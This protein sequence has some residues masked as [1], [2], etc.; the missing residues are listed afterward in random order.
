VDAGF[1]QPAKVTLAGGTVEFM[2]SDTGGAIRGP[3]GVVVL[4]AAEALAMRD[5]ASA[6]E[7]DAREAGL[8]G[9]AERDEAPL[10]DTRR[11]LWKAIGEDA[12]AIMLDTTTYYNAMAALGRQSPS[13]RSATPAAF[14][15]LDLAALTVA[16]VCFDV[17]VI[18]PERYHPGD[19]F[20][21]FTYTLP[22]AERDRKAQDDLGREAAATCARRSSRYQSAWAAFLGLDGQLS[23]DFDAALKFFEDGLGDTYGYAAALGFLERSYGELHGESAYL[24]IQTV[25]AVYNDRVAGLLGLPYLPTS[26]RLP[27]AA[28]LSRSRAE[29]LDGIRLL[30][31]SAPGSEPARPQSPTTPPAPLYAPF[32]LGLVL[33]RMNSPDEFEDA[34]GYWRDRFAP[35]RSWLRTHPQRE[36]WQAQPHALRRELA[37]RM[38]DVTGPSNASVSETVAFEVLQGAASLTP[39]GPFAGSALKILRATQPA[40]GLRRLMARLFKPELYLLFS[41]SDEARH[42]ATLDADITR[43]WGRRLTDDSRDAL[44]RIRRLNSDR[45]L[46]PM[47]M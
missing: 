46:S 38:H 35:F 11:A 28:D 31:Q 3:Q 16:G 43:I 23:L 42:V 33:A 15:L 36:L 14:H 1:S 41:I 47:T 26:I 34:V 30:A 2:L 17:V 4:T 45:L 19:A 39:V 27:V 29:L 21:D 7:R 18:Q 44:E 5:A 25:R 13:P 37:A 10:R 32:L 9:A 8:A 40:S 6:V 24:P 12:L 20:A 22:V